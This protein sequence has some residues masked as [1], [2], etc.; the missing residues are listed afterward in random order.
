MGREPWAGLGAPPLLCL[1]AASCCTPA[2]LTE[3][4]IL[5]HLCVP[6][7]PFAHGA[8]AGS[9]PENRAGLSLRQRWRKPPGAAASTCSAPQVQ[10]WGQHGALRPAH[11]PIGA[12]PFAALPQQEGQRPRRAWGKV[13]CSL[14]LSADSAHFAPT[15]SGEDPCPTRDTSPSTAVYLKTGTLGRAD[16]NTWD[17]Y[18]CF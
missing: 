9:W 18:P 16:A 8:A 15:S 12:G 2:L 4:L 17:C 10:G 11:P 3:P 7:E 6:T 13:C 1:Q 14:E 5:L